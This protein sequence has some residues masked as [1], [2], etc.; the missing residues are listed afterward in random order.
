VLKR[1][2][3]ILLPSIVLVGHVRKSLVRSPTPH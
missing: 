2:L 3:V 1:I